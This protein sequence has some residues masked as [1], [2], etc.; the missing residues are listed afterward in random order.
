MNP[1]VVQPYAEIDVT[2][3]PLERSESLGTKPKR[4]LR[5]P[6]TRQRW[7]MKDTTYNTS[8]DGRRSPKGD[9]WAE[10]IATGVAECLDV[11]AA[12]TELATRRIGSEHRRGV[13]SLSILEEHEALVLGNELLAQPVYRHD[14]AGYTVAA[15]RQALEGVDDPT[16]AGGERSAW[17]VFTG[18]LVL[19]ALIGNTD[20]HEENWG[21]IRYGDS[22]RL[23]PT[24]DHASSLGFL[25]DDRQRED[26]L[27]TRD[28]AYTPEKWAD[29]AKSPFAGKPHPIAVAI[30]ACETLDS[31]QRDRWLRGC[32]DVDRLVEPIR[33]VPEHR[34]SRPAREFAERVLRRNRQR[35]LSACAG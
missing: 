19:D 18:Y 12:R 29:R 13:I 33:R 24:F 23:A 31:R 26:R 1:P 6:E 10:R 3:W 27:A 7:L 34:M 32:E 9:D 2:G 28:R 5:D 8:A 4:W 21:V 15:I 22:H 11:P 30:E 16:G 14:R 25:L 35:L 20:R 17:D